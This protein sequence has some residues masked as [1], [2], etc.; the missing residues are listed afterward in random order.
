MSSEEIYIY[1][2]LM[3]SDA[4]PSNKIYREL[5]GTFRELS[6]KEITFMTK[7]EDIVKK[8]DQ[9]TFIFLSKYFI[10]LFY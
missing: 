4:L 2:K 3:P 5:I 7:L 6:T 9:V 1:N 8:N 10:I